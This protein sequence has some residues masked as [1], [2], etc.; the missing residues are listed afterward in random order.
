MTFVEQHTEIY[1]VYLCKLV[2][3]FQNWHDE[4]N[5]ENNSISIQVQFSQINPC[6]RVESK[7]RLVTKTVISP[8]MQIYQM[9]RLKKSAEYTLHTT[10]FKKNKQAKKGWMA[11]GM[12]LSSHARD[13]TGHLSKQTWSPRHHL[14]PVY[15]TFDMSEVLLLLCDERDRHRW[16][17]EQRQ[18]WLSGDA[19]V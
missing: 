18:R 10:V 1:C 4:N 11:Q 15:R 5:D 13:L 8:I 2:Y 16:D 6:T 9:F 7:K 3:I 14:G 17:G 12:L 19:K